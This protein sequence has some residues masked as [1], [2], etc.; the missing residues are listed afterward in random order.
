[1]SDADRIDH[2]ASKALEAARQWRTVS[3]EERA[4]FLV[5]LAAALRA[6]IDALVDT[7]QAE[8]GLPPARLRTE[9]ERTAVQLE[10]FATVVKEGSYLDARIDEEDADFALGVRPDLRRVMRPLGP[11][12]VFSASNFPFAFSV[13]GGDTASAL[14][15]GCS[16]VVKAHSGHPK[17]SALVVEL[18][19]RVADEL[20]I[21]PDVLQ[22]VYRQDEGIALLEHPAIAAASFTGSTHVGRSL[23]DRAALRPKPIPFFGELG[24]LNPVF[25]TPAAVARDADA[26]VQGLVTSI[27]GSA[28]QLCTKPGFVFLP[29]GR[30]LDDRL[31][32][33]AS[34][35]GELRMLTPS[36][37]RGYEARRSEILSTPGVETVVE[38]S[39]RF[40]DDL[41]VVT[42]TIVR[43]DVENLRSRSHLVDEAF[44]PLTILV[45]YDNVELLESVAA[46]LFEGNLTGTVHLDEEDAHH[47]A[48]AGLV[49]ALAD[50]CGRVVFNGWPTG[51]AVTS[52]MQHGGP[53]PAT[54]ADTSTSVGSAAIGRFLRPVTYQ[55]APESL[56]PPEL[57]DDNTL[58]V[59]RSVSRAGASRAWGKARVV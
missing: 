10:M 13:L 36:V 5:A 59:P 21:D 4:E 31:R 56:L 42:P 45:E 54:T 17:L 20:S 9:V 57:R 53:W 58:D 6:S 23:A 12:L 16:V 37:S 47:P 30:S 50:L 26:I 14:A 41:A 35:V 48:I 28:G 11:V 52:A 2:I 46:E 44:G 27:S 7:A 25:I 33:A 43:T 8:T 18:A 22:A 55:N 51:V 38:G 15:A 1:M 24:S 29:P 19:R 39:V 34:D 40:Q 32:S 3:A 49:D